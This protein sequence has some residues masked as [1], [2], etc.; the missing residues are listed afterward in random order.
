MAAMCHRHFL[1]KQ[2]VPVCTESDS[3]NIGSIMVLVTDRVAIDSHVTSLR[4]SELPCG[5]RRRLSA[6]MPGS[7]VR[8]THASAVSQDS[9][10]RKSVPLETPI[11]LAKGTPMRDPTSQ[12]HLIYL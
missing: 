8:A 2:I 10:R 11:A 9:Q 6:H 3:C 1:N 7:I 5:G 12:T 4:R